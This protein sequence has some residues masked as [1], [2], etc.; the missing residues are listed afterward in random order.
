MSVVRDEAEYW[1]ERAEEV[2]RLATTFAE[3][4]R[5]RKLLGIAAKYEEMARDA[6]MN[7]KENACCE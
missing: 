5:A 6:R 1:R 2:R 3:H 4:G 7:I